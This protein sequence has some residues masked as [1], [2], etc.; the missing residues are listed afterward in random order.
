[1]NIPDTSTPVTSTMPQVTT[2]DLPGDAYPDGSEAQI[3][4]TPSAVIVLDGVPPVGN[5]LPR[6][7]WYAHVLGQEL[8]RT[9]TVSAD[10]TLSTALE[11]AISAVACEHHLAP[12]ASPAATL[13]MACWRAD[14]LDALVLGGGRVVAVMA[15]GSVEAIADNRPARLIA[16][17]PEHATLRARLMVGTG[18]FDDEHQ[19]LLRRLRDHQL[20]HLNQPGRRGYWMAEATKEAAQHAVTTSWPTRDLEAVLVMTG[21]VSAVVTDYKIATWSHLARLCR[22]D[23]AQQVV[24]LVHDAEAGDPDGRRWPRCQ[25]HAGKALAALFPPGGAA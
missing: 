21:G 25:R 18:G 17:Y 15:D 24:Q 12:K 11:S 2:G 22:T 5:H 4:R 6:G 3:A 20:R 13:S 9:L 16:T 14:R 1:M 8:A 19:G 23:G 10:L 7:D